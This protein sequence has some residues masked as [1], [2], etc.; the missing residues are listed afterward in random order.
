MLLL[1][2]PVCA[3]GR[4]TATSMA[5]DMAWPSLKYAMAIGIG[6]SWHYI[7]AFAP[8]NCRINAATQY[9]CCVNL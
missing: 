7:H 5:I 3:H 6:I 9:L 1:A 8:R 4:S 2:H